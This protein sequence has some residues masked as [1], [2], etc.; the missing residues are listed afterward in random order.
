MQGNS[1]LHCDS[2]VKE[3]VAPLDFLAYIWKVQSCGRHLLSLGMSSPWDMGQ[4]LQDQQ[5]FG[6]EASAAVS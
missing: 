6:G 4:T 1:G 3:I 2:L 5:G